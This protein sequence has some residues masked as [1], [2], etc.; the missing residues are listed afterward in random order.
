MSS[1]REI[2]GSLAGLQRTSPA[3][4]PT[5]FITGSDINPTNF[6][7]VSLPDQV[8]AAILLKS[9]PPSFETLTHQFFNGQAK[10]LTSSNVYE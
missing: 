10:Y 9:L 6:I 1:M 8:V 5:I 7:N 2:Q 3:A 4:T